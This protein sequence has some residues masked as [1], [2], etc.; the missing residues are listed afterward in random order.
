M[1]RA[2]RVEPL[3]LEQQ[4]AARRIVTEHL[5]Q[6]WW[7]TGSWAAADRAAADLLDALKAEHVELVK[8]DW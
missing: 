4:L 5:M 7:T 3:D 2:P 6:A 1:L 8:V